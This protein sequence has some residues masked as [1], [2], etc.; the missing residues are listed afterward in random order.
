MTKVKILQ[1]TMVAGQRHAKGD[2][3]EISENSARHLTALGKAEIFL[4]K[5]RK[6]G[7]MDIPAKSKHKS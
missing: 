6:D 4:E 5:Q 1:T 2:I 3:I 7:N